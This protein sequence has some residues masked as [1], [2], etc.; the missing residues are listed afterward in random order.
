MKFLVVE[1]TASQRGEWR[2]APTLHM[3]GALLCPMRERFNLRVFPL[4]DLLPHAQVTD[5]V[6]S[7]LVSLHPSMGFFQYFLWLTIFKV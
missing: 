2:R 5:D 6:N 7:P 1:H 3:R 4:S